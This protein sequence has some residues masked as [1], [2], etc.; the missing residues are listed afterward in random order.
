MS[1]FSKAASKPCILEK[2]S[3]PLHSGLLLPKLAFADSGVS[4]EAFTIVISLL[5]RKLA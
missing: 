5:P 3:Q 2:S 1:P 4:I